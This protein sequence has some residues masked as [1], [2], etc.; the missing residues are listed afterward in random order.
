MKKVLLLSSL[1]AFSLAAQAQVTLTGTSYTQNFDGIG[2]GLPT[3]WSVYSGASATGTGNLESL[4]TSTTYGI[5]YDTT[6]GCAVSSVLGGGFKN[7]PS[8]S[9]AAPN[10]SCTVQES[11]TNRAL[12]VR[13]VSPT[14]ATHPNLDSGASFNFQV[15]NTAGLSNVACSFRL[16]SLD[17]ASP[18]ITT[19]RVYYKIGASGTWTENTTTG[20]MT[21]G[22][23]M[24]SDNPITVNFGSALNNQSS[25]VYVRICTIDFSSGSGNRPSTAID[26]F[27]MTWSGTAGVN[28]VAADSKIALNVTNASTSSIG[29]NFD[30]AE[31]GDYTLV[32]TDMAG[33]TVATKQVA[34]VHGNQNVTFN[35]LSLAPGML[36]AKL[37]NGQNA[38]ITKVMVN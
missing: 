4:S 38:G 30:A 6:S 17:S 22:G 12:G 9:S 19:W 33:R 14:N 29:L 18:R 23:N 34:V 28:D 20:T 27:K 5:Y 25:N 15:A 1:V 11:M 8:A 37:S 24:F 26:S 3:G 35:G 13:Q 21:T 36:I 32:L 7:Y 16:Q 2:G 31:A 10:T